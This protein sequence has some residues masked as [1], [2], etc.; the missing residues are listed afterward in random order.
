M[1]GTD[2]TR[3]LPFLDGLRGL[4]SLY[5]L[6]FHQMTLT[7]EG[8]GEL[9]GVMKVLRAWFGEGHF[10]VV[11]FIVL[12]GFSLMLPLARGGVE[13]LRGKLAQFAFR[14][15]RRIMPPYYAALLLS[16]AV[17][18]A[19]NVLAPRLGIGRAV[20]GALDAGSIISHL[21]LVH[22]LS[23]DW[24]YRINGPMWSVAT[25]WQIYFL[26]ALALL[27]LLRVGGSVVTVIA[28]WAVGSLPFFLLPDSVN[29][30][31]AC[32]WFIGSFA[33]GMWGAKIGFAPEHLD[34]YARER[35]PWWILAW[36]SF[37]AI[38]AI[39][40]TGASGSLGYPIVDFVVSVFAFCW[41]NANVQTVRMR[42]EQPSALLRFLGSRPL[43]ELG[44]F[45]YSLYL[46]QH[47]VLRFVEKLLAR[48]PFDLNTLLAIQL[49]LG[50]PV[51]LFLAWLFAEF[52]ERPFTGGGVV[53][54]ALRRK[55]SP[56]RAAAS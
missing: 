19:Y 17:L 4:A 9:T 46:I 45:S 54:P 56:D 35:L 16:I 23:F 42:P 44:A 48:L 7:I 15:A 14:R 6:L 51:M 29:L 52:F 47:P 22:N 25:E 49:V 33:F 37:A 31:W 38:V 18:G 10:S 40:W 11:F 24:A 30:F 12:S 2:P 27:P 34:S 53:L 20:E 3:R 1:S 5:V 13:T 36:L 28:S 43:V 21:L 50:T 41:I 26:F 55:F 32:P 8:H 39:C